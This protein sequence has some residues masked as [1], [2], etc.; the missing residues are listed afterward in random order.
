MEKYEFREQ[1]ASEMADFLI[2]ILDFVPEKRLTAAQCLNHPW[3]NGGPSKVA[4]SVSQPEE[5]DSGIS[6]KKRDKD[7]REAMEVRVGNMAID[8]ASRPSKDAI[9]LS[10]R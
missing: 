6:N 1:D 7:E 9:S 2:Q 8:G 3:I 4:P 5:V 10:S